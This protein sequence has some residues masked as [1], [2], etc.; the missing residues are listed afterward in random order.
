MHIKPST[1]IVCLDRK[2]ASGGSI[3]RPV[4]SGAASGGEDESA[5]TCVDVFNLLNFDPLRVHQSL[6]RY[7]L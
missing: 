5:G 7:R 4:E 3:D 1:I 6:K 2:M